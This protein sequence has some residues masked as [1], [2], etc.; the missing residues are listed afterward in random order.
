MYVRVSSVGLEPTD[1]RRGH[2]TPCNGS[3][4][5]LWLP[6]GVLKTESRASL[7]TEPSLQPLQRVILVTKLLCQYLLHSMT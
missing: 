2:L 5:C 1:T 3:N 4:R 6:W 7:T